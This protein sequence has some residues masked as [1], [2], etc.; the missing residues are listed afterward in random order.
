MRVLRYIEDGLAAITYVALLAMMAL[1]TVDAL[2]RYLL[3][4]TP[5]DVFHFTEL[6][7]MPLV[8]FF[9][10]AQTQRKR[11]HVSVTLL[12]H[13]FPP[14]LASCVLAAVYLAAGIICAM[15]AYASW[16]AAWP[17]LINWRVTGGVVPWPTGLSRVIVPI[18]MGL[19]SVRL[20]IDAGSEVRAALT[21][22]QPT[23]E[24]DELASD[25]R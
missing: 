7:L 3:R 18:G 22:G 12:N 16:Q 23:A 10:M 5:P 13:Y 15:I 14:A 17:H 21:G 11:G 8:I 2:G 24:P 9:A 6:Y 4:I 19:L 1:I 20:L 25:P